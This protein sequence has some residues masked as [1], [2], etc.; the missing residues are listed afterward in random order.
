MA[1]PSAKNSGFDKMSNR[2]FGLELASRIV[3]MDSAVRH[4][5][6]DFSTTIL[7]EVATAAIRRVASSTYLLR[8]RSE[9]EYHLCHHLGRKRCAW[10]THLR[11][12]RLPAAGCAKRNR[13]ANHETTGNANAYLRSAANPEPTP[14]FFVGVLTDTKMRSASRMPLSTSVEKNRFL[15]LAWRTTP[16]SPGS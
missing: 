3:L 8:E 15:P 5:T 11:K 7:D 12:T 14:D 2:A 1:V 6:V 13:G 10:R 9:S 16:S 4:G